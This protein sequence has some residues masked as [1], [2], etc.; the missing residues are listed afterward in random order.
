M[1]NALLA[2]LLVAFVVVLVVLSLMLGALP[3][4]GR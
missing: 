1:R 2:R 3:G 4:P